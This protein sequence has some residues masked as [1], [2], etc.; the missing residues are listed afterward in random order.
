MAAR[1]D[2]I[3]AELRA[4]ISRGAHPAGWRLPAE[5]ELAAEYG[6]N[7]GTVRRAMATLEAEGIIERRHGVGTFVKEKRQR[8]S[9]SS[10]RYQW[11]KNRTPL[12]D[13]DRRRTGATE[14]DTGLE[15]QD[16]RFSAR[17]Q[18]VSADSDVAEAMSVKE[19]TPLLRRTYET[20]RVGEN[21]PLGI[22]TSYLLLD[23]IEGNSDLLDE[24]KEPWPGGTQHQLS[25]VG[26]EI[27]RIDDRVTARPATISEATALD[28][29]PGEPI[30]AL[31]KTS[32]DTHGRVVEVADI[33]WPGDRIELHYPTR[34]A[35]WAK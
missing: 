22:A 1:Y 7:L 18:T 33:V 19:G 11:E 13:E 28:V 26:V 16:L 12:S 30:L 23:L 15:L 17:Y 2:R 5:T 34:L 8:I 20:R 3:A 29:R 14:F 9:R 21:A 27:D 4:K 10:E 32:I 24:A 35:R 31:R 6:A 25:T